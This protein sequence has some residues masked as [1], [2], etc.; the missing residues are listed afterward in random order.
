ME[1][2]AQNAAVTA[3]CLSGTI[4]MLMM[5]IFTGVTNDCNQIRSLG[6]KSSALP[7]K[8]HA[9][10]MF[11]EFINDHHHSEKAET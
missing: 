8:P 6:Y 7:T 1:K 5:E 9:Y 3:G 2:A 11:S 10:P 4:N